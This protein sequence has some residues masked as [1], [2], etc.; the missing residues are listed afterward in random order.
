MYKINPICEDGNPLSLSTD[1]QLRVV[2]IGVGSAFCKRKRQSNILII[3]GDHH[4]LV[5]CGTQGPLALNDIG[6]SVLDVRCYLPTHSHADHVGGFEEVMLMNRYS[7]DNNGRGLP[8]LIILRDYQDLLWSK[9][10]S[11][12]AEFCEA[13]QGRTLQI[14]D[15]FDVLRPKTQQIHGRKVW[16]YQHGPMEIMIMRTRHFPDTAVSV[17]ESQWCSGVFINRR[18]WISGD[19]MFDQE[20]PQRF[21]EDAEVMFHDCQLFNGGVHASYE[22]LMTLPADIRKKMFLYHFGDN[23]DQINTWVK[24]DNPFSGEPQKDGFLGWAQQQMA[25]DFK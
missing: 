8:Q 3:Q 14:T 24:P 10:L 9:S 1:G 2:F 7:P 17:D 23:W 5:D 4:V 15:F 19:T 16:V 6:L 25:Y 11:G 12:G 13:N 21:A 22:E 20:Y 18:V